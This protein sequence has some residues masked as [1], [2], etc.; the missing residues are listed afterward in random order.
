MELTTDQQQKLYEN[1]MAVLGS[2]EWTDVSQLL[3]VVQERESLQ[4]Q[5]TG[6]LMEYVQKELQAEVHYV[7]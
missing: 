1:I 4:H 2:I 3:A 5:V 6:A 7:D